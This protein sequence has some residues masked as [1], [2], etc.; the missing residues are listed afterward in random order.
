V[1]SPTIDGNILENEWNESYRE[2][3]FLNQFQPEYGPQMEDS[4]EIYISY[5]EENIYFL[6]KSYQDTLTLISK[7]S[8]SDGGFN[9]DW[10]GVIIDPLATK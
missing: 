6:L 5:D 4:T 2:L 8:T 10:V 1:N 3:V 7:T 9:Q